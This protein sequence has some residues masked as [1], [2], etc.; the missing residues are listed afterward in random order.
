[1]KFFI[2]LIALALV[3]I[4]GCGEPV[5]ATSTGTG[6]TGKLQGGGQQPAE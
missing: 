2:A 4:A 6:K 3:I 1:M 5:E